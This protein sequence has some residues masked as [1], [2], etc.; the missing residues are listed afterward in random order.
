MRKL[1]TI[2]FFLISF[3]GIAQPPGYTEG[4][5]APYT[6]AGFVCG[7]N[8]PVGWSN[9]VDDLIVFFAGDFTNFSLGSFNAQTPGIQYADAGINY[10]GTRT[11]N[12]VTRKLMILV[13]FHVDGNNMPAYAAIIDAFLSGHSPSLTA[14]PRSRTHMGGLSGGVGR[15]LSYLTNQQSHNSPNR[16][17]FGKGLWASCAFVAHLGTGVTTDTNFV[18]HGTGDTNPGT[19]PSQ[20]RLLFTNLPG[21]EGV[22]KFRDST[23]GGTHGEGTWGDFF[24]TTPSPNRFEWMINTN[25]GGAPP[26]LTVYR[27]QP[28]SANSIALMG[29]TRGGARVP[30]AL[31]DGTTATQI[32]Q[33]GGAGDLLYY[34]NEMLYIF[35]SAYNDVKFRI[36]TGSGSPAVTVILYNELFTDSLIV[37][38]PSGDFNNWNWMDTTTTKAWAHSMRFAKVLMP[39]AIHL[40]EAEFWG[41]ANG[42]PPVEYFPN[43]TTILNTPFT[44]FHGEN[45]NGDEKDSLLMS[46][47]SI[48]ANNQTWI[49]DTATIAIGVTHGNHRFVYNIFGNTA[50][51]LQRWR[52]SGLRAFTYS[53][54]PSA[55]NMPVPRPYTGVGQDHFSYYGAYNQYKNIPPGSDSTNRFSWRDEAKWHASVL[56][57]FGP[58]NP[59]VNTSGYENDIING[60]ALTEGLDYFFATEAGNEDMADFF[61]EERYHSPEVIVAKMWAVYDSSK[62]KCPS[63]PVLQGAMTFMDTNN[64]K[65]MWYYSYRKRGFNSYPADVILFNHYIT[66]IGGQSQLPTFGVHPEREST[67]EEAQAFMM[68]VRKYLGTKQVWWTEVGWDASINS[69]YRSKIIGSKSARRVAGDWLGRIYVQWRAAGGDGIYHYRLRDETNDPTSA[70]AFATMGIAT[71]FNPDADSSWKRWPGW[72]MMSTQKMVYTPYSG[73]PDILLHGD[74]TGVWLYRDDPE[75]LNNVVTLTAHMGTADDSDTTIT[76]DTG[77]SIAVAWRINVEYGPEDL[78]TGMRYGDTVAVTIVDGTKLLLSDIGETMSFFQ[79]VYGAPSNQPPVA[80]AGGDISITLPLDSTILNGTGSSDIDGA[81][82]LYS[83]VKL[84]GPSTF[85]ISTPTASSTW[86]KN[87]IEGVYTFELTVTDNEGAT[88]KDTVQVTVN[89]SPPANIPPIA[90]AGNNQNVQLPTSS[91]TLDGSASNDPDGTITTYAWTKVGGPASFTIQSPGSASTIVSNLIEGVYLFRLVVTDDDAVT[92]DDT[93]QVTVTEQVFNQQPVVIVGPDQFVYSGTNVVI[94]A[95]ASYDPDGT[96]V[97]YLWELVSAPGPVSIVSPTAASTLITGMIQPGWYTFIMTVTDNSGAMDNGDKI[98]IVVL[99]NP[100]IRSRY[101]FKN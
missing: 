65:A 10:N 61:T 29:G 43:S 90:F 41:V 27:I 97:S 5:N 51:I 101:R 49:S 8:R 22:E 44:E 79:F 23:I 46:A 19:P 59:G 57:R 37:F 76:Y 40:G 2:L 84:T 89:A 25:P 54:G 21:T 86:I 34:P 62:A 18:W 87:L 11:V 30:F 28:T 88:D 32:H 94:D 95:S 45:V 63:C 3:S 78:N 53:Q 16:D 85:S 93:V 92:D 73:P 42:D 98:T 4:T 7:Y 52:D 17:N 70:G 67:M 13:I 74:S 31:F 24:K 39:Q 36:W 83:W 47:Y 91:V 100:L 20:S 82:D 71:G 68:K 96:I 15:G 58:P 33:S 50:E 66:D 64:I 72:Y 6:L 12:G 56:L 38:L 80:Y 48:R 26:P 60:M 69:S 99:P 77:D 9:T 35:D 1:I 75:G 14:M 55:A 81:V